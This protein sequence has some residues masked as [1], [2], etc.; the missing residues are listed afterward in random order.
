VY[1]DDPRVR[2]EFVYETERHRPAV[3]T[4]D[5][6]L[7][8]AI[9]EVV[10][11]AVEGAAVVPAAS[12]VGTDN[13]FLRRVGVP[14]YGFIPCLLSQEERDGFHAHNEFLALDNFRMGLELTYE[15]ARRVCA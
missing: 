6:A 11:E 4:T 10:R 15:I 13:R 9:E 7:Y 12:I 14:A 8:R 1:V 2:V 5:T 3:A